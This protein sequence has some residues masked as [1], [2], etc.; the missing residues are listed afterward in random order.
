MVQTKENIIKVAIK[1]FICLIIPAITLFI[2]KLASNPHAK[3]DIYAIRYMYVRYVMPEALILAFVLA[4]TVILKKG[5][6]NKSITLYKILS[7]LS[8]ILM[9]IVVYLFIK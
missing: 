6:S 5:I 3:K 7:G 2:I 9:S 1:T 4:I 8:L